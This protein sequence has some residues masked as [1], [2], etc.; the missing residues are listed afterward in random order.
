VIHVVISTFKLFTSLIKL[1]GS[2]LNEKQLLIS[3]TSFHNVPPA[4]LLAISRVSKVVCILL[5]PDYNLLINI[6]TVNWS[7]S[8]AAQIE[9]SHNVAAGGKL[10][11]SP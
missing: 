6:I 10:A 8:M 5:S 2:T 3:D 11:V 1:V 9:A 4:T 7:P